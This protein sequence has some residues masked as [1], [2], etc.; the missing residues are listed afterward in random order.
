MNWQDRIKQ[1]KQK[2]FF[3][4]NDKLDAANWPACAVG[5]ILNLPE[6]AT[7]NDVPIKFLLL[8]EDFDRA[9]RLNEFSI[10]ENIYSQ[11]QERAQIE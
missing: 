7:S 10:A 11:I 5:E 6:D 2:G 4:Y 1:A 9:V 3:S 8:G